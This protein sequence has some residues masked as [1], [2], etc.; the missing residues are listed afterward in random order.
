M[1]L[2]LLFGAPATF[3]DA[4]DTADLVQTTFKS[5]SVGA[6]FSVVGAATAD[7]VFAK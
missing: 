5:V 6:I 1:I 3:L 2:A 7:T 4:S